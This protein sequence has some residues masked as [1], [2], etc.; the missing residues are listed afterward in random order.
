[1]RF[2][3]LFGQ[4]N[5]K[6][7]K[8]NGDIDALIEALDFPDDHN[9]RFEA[10][11]ALGDV[12]DSRCIAPLISAL[13]DTERVREVA[14][15]SLGKIG[16]QQAIPPLVEALQDTN[17]EIRS[18]AAKS[19]GTIGDESAI[20]PLINALEKETESV[21]WYIVQALS[22]IT[23]ED[24]IQDADEWKAWLQQNQQK[25]NHHE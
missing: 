5:I 13:N 14:I 3:G 17:W 18:M 20:E 7:M 23:G 22:N 10:A 2:F 19:L 4:P 9:V 25:G 11:S 1:M 12:G 16:D 8:D 6:E 21:R 15:R 24:F